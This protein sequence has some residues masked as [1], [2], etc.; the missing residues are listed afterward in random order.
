MSLVSLLKLVP[1]ALLLPAASSAVEVKATPLPDAPARNVV[2]IL[3]DDHRYDAMGFMD[4]PFLKTPAMDA[5]AAEGVHLKNAFVT[6]SLCS[7]SR[8]SIL[9]GLYTHKHRVIDNNRPVP[10]GTRFFPEW[11]QAAGYRT[12]FIGKWHMGNKSDAPRPG[13]D[14][15][16]SFRG[17]GNYWPRKN[18]TLNVNGKRVPQEGYLTDELTN[19]A[20]AWLREQEDSDQP[21]FLYLSHKAV[22]ANF[23]PAKRHQGVYEEAEFDRPKTQDPRHG[24]P[25]HR[26]RWVRDQRNSWHGVDFPYHRKLD[27]ERYYK[28]YC[29][30]LLAVDDSIQQVMD[31]LEAMEIADETLVIYM[32]DNGFMFGEHGL[33]DKRV[34]YETSIRVPML[35]RCPDL[36]EGGTVVEEVVAN[37]DIAPTILETAGLKKPEH[38]DGMSMVPIARGRNVPWRHHFLYIYYWEKNYPHSPTVFCLRGERYKLMHYYGLWDADE[39]YDIQKD[40]TESHNLIADPDFQEIEREM[41]GKLY[42]MLEEAGA[43][44]IPMNN[45]AG[46]RGARMRSRERGG[47][48]AADFPGHF[49]TGSE[50]K[51]KSKK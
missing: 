3:S 13:F 19:Y 46:I 45:L 22:H 5:L 18:S 12:A 36:F 29:E 34:A 17:Q 30:A 51:E 14:H 48:K 6:T 21:F 23:S 41:A 24:D 9:T 49:V 27:V 4:H 25:D 20:V 28:R 1:L 7:P 43:M 40:P 32:G 37:I 42:A 47:E 50:K 10:E 11:L 38:M 26:P 31:Q 33:I 44:N 35:M 2:F 8:A 39:L 15:W 16:I